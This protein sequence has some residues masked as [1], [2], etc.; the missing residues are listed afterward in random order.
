MIVLATDR[1]KRLLAIHGWSGAVLGL[2]LYVVVLTGAVAVF[3]GDI[4]AWAV[5]GADHRDPLSRWVGVAVSN[6]AAEIPDEYE[7]DISIFYDNRGD[8]R[9]F[10]HTHAINP[11]GD[12]DGKGVMVT[13]DTET[14]K[15]LSWQ[16]GFGADLFS[17]DPAEALTRFLV[18]LHVT[19]HVPD[20]WGLYLTGL[21]GFLMLSAAVSGFLLH[22]HLIRDLFVAPRLSSRLL[23]A[24]DRH[25]LAGTWGLLFAVTLAFTG[26]FFSFAAPLGLPVV[27]MVAFGGDQDAMIETLSGAPAPEDPRPA[28]FVNLDGVLRQ[29]AL[30]AGT[31]A[32]FVSVEHRGRADARISLFH[33]PPEGG[34]RTVQHV[35]DG[36]TGLFLGVKPALGTAP[37]AGDTVFGVMSALHFGTFAGFLSRLIWFGLGL[38]MAYVTLTGLQLWLRRREE[39]PGWRRIGRAVPAVGY[40]L[41]IALCGATA[42][43]FLSLGAGTTGFWTPVG[44]LLSAIPPL[45][46][47]WRVGDPLRLRRYVRLALGAALFGLPLL[48]LLLADAGWID[49]LA[50][51]ESAVVAM[52]LVL[53]LAGGGL[54]FAAGRRR[55]VSA[56]AGARPEGGK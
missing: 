8:L 15:V 37:S 38:A 34:F 3:A 48:R 13:L 52:D 36:T 51:A 7:Q 54:L 11:D 9:F 39:A 33:R 55:G 27:S 2:L 40:G 28:V 5:S 17:A 44:F 50:R 47:A 30:R 53:L 42:G 1:T 19:L 4:G 16:E 25:I 43:F 29:S 18:D 6:L 21:L 10:F 46:L 24:R 35:Y 20:P 23:Q 22:R 14:H 56:F 41:P 26:A 49:L 45:V 12:L 32:T 31:Q